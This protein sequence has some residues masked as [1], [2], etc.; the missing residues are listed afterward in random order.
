MKK[1]LNIIP[2]L[3]IIMLIF[4]YLGSMGASIFSAVGKIYYIGV[5]FFCIIYIA[6]KLP[7]LT[8]KRNYRI[9][10]TFIIFL[11]FYL[12]LF[13]FIRN[14][15]DNVFF[16]LIL[17]IFFAF[18]FIAYRGVNLKYIG[19]VSTI[20]LY[21]FFIITVI[22]K[23]TYFNPN[24][25]AFISSELYFF[26]VFFLEF[27]KKKMRRIMF[28]I[29]TLIGL[30]LSYIVYN[31]ATQ[32]ICVG[33]FAFIFMIRK[34]KFIKSKIFYYLFVTSIFLFVMLLP[35]VVVFFINKGILDVTFFTSRG[36]RWVWA[37]DG[38]KEVGIFN[39]YTKNIG[40]HN[41]YMEMALKYSLVFA[42]IYMLILFVTLLS[43][44]KI[45]RRNKYARTLILI[46]MMFILM[47][48]SE[49]FFV[50]LTD[51][52]FL[53]IT[54]AS[55]ISFKCINVKKRELR[56]YCNGNEVTC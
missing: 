50:G 47:N 31:S 54:F 26:S 33:L 36:E 24:S 19:L 25:Y 30:F 12:L 27:K 13:I 9:K 17:F 5:S 8:S 38:I 29:N 48:N 7:K 14:S 51:A 53:V 23:C 55:L 18:A 4:P 11:V 41:G 45:Y 15:L 39:V 44:Y 32:L 34:M 20:G 37:I 28:T 43:C 52:Y 40:A 35:V 3:I 1:I 16:G 22:N 56:R 2:T 42:T 21:L 6:F 10:M 49:S 46:F